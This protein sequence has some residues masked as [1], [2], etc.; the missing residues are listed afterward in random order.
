MHPR[1]HVLLLLLLLTLKSK[2]R[3]QMN[4]MIMLQLLRRKET[5]NPA[6]RHLVCFTLCLFSVL[7]SGSRYL[8]VQVIT[9]ALWVCGCF[10][11]SSFGYCCFDGSSRNFGALLIKNEEDKE[12]NNKYPTF[13]ILLLGMPFQ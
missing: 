1:I 11:Q 3:L 5:T 13:L 9:S 4:Q 2:Q 7:L 6:P 8:L 10:Y 12:R